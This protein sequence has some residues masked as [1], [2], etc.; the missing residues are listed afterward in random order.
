MSGYGFLGDKLSGRMTIMTDDGGRTVYAVA[1]PGKYLTGMDIEALKITARSMGARVTDPTG[2]A[3]EV[4]RTN[5][6]FERQ[7][8]EGWI[9]PNGRDDMLSSETRQRWFKEEM[10]KTEQYMQDDL[11]EIGK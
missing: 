2:A 10:E 4:V 1:E 7:R 8:I 11:R 3:E 6:R 5:A 9:G